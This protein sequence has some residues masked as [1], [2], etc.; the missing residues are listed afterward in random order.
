MVRAMTSSGKPW[1]EKALVERAV[2]AP[3]RHHSA[4]VGHPGVFCPFRRVDSLPQ[5]DVPVF[6]R[7]YHLTKGWAKSVE[8]APLVAEQHRC[9]T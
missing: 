5:R 2:S 9:A 1:R 7:L 4:T 3:D 6:V 8:P